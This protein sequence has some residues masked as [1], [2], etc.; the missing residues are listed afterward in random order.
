MKVWPPH[1]QR[2]EQFNGSVVVDVQHF[3]SVAPEDPYL[4]ETFTLGKMNLIKKYNYFTG[5]WSS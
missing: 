5:Q 1:P 4:Y 2:A 3:P